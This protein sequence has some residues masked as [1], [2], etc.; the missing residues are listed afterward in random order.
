MVNN[1]HFS[2][3]SYTRKEVR[4]YTFNRRK[5]R[6]RIQHTRI[7]QFSLIETSPSPPSIV[8]LTILLDIYMLWV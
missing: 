6:K 5:F 4:L 2:T 7:S 1:C 8:F 3:F